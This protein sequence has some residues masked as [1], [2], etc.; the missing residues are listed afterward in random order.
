MDWKHVME[1]LTGFSAE[2]QEAF[3]HAWSEGDT[4]KMEALV[5]EQI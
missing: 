2:R 1:V 5:S 4:A 3:D